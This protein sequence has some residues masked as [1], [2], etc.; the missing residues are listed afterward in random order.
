MDIFK[1]DK[2]LF[3]K[4]YNSGKPQLLHTILS[5]DLNTPVSILLKLKNEKYSF[6]FES[7]E[8]GSNKGRYSV[9][10]I[11]PDLIWKC[12]NQKCQIYQVNNNNKKKII[13]E[14][15]RKPIESLKNLFK[16]NKFKIP[17]NLPPMS[18]GLFGYL[19][20]DMIKYFENI[21]LENTNELNLPESIFIRPT[22]MIIFDNVSDKLFI[23]NTVWP[24]LKGYNEA[25]QNSLNEVE[26]IL[27][28]ISKPLNLPS[29]KHQK[30]DYSNEL[31]LQKVSSNTSY[32]QFKKMITKAKK[33]IFSGDIFQVVLSRCFKKKI[34][35][36]SISIYRALRY[37]NPSPY[38]FFMN[39]DNFSIVGSSPEILVKLENDI[40]TIRPI[41]GTRKRGKNLKEDLK[42]ENEL[43]NDPKEISEHLMLLDLGRNDISRVTKPGTVEVTEQMFVEY[44]SHVMHIVSNINGKIKKGID[45]VDAL[46]GGFPAGTVSGAPKIRAM[47]IIEELEE[48]KRNIYAGAI[49][50]LSANG[51]LDSCIALRTA[52]I[53]DNYIYIQ[54]GAGIV[55]DSDSRSEFRETENKA[56]ALL[57]AVMYS[58]NF[59]N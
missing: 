47:E 20:Y 7:V 42:L 3:K 28:L 56:M 41:A 33:Y 19:G 23:I 58:K 6:L 50:Y 21:N 27:K 39:F 45:N 52:V 29:N 44:F 12:E 9:I 49:G 57:Q 18:S 30:L 34:T 14:N 8:K 51:N 37:L 48:S 59:K 24:N 25:F 43:L 15:K 40:V 16:K 36:S 4:N 31:L 2:K 46:L 1:P 32:K 5:A 35:T 17:E 11:K 26:K 13:L 22:I 53:K 38:L 54:S 55:A 10:G